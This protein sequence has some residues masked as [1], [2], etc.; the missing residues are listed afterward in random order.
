M[1][2][3]SLTIITIA[4]LA[5]L[6]LLGGEPDIP[7]W[8]Q[9]DTGYMALRMMDEW[10][11][12]MLHPKAPYRGA[13]DVKA[14]EYPIYPL[15]VSLGYKIVGQEYLPWARVV[16]LLF[17]AGSMVFLAL[18]VGRL[19]GEPVGWLTA[20]VYAILPLG[21]PYSRM[22]HPDFCVMFFANG[23]FYFAVLFMERRKVRDAVVAVIFCSGLFLMKAPYG[24]YFGF[25]LGL[26]AL[27]AD[28]KKSLRDL[29]LLASL[30]VIPLGLGLWF[31]DYR[32]QQEAPFEESLTYPMKWTKES[33]NARFFGTI[34][35]R[36]DG[37][38]WN[39]TIK[40]AV[41][42][43]STAPGALLAL[44]GLFL[45][46]R[47]W[48][49]QRRWLVWFL[50]LGMLAYVLL[51][52]PMVASDHDYYSIP[53][54]V[55]VSVLVAI[56]LE[57][58][59]RWKWGAGLVAVSMVLILAGSVYGLQRGPFLYSSPY[60]TRDWQRLE[61]SRVIRET[62][63]PDDLVVSVT[64]GRST[65]WSDPRILW[66]ADRRGWAIE[67]ERLSEDHLNMYRKAGAHVAAIF[68]APG[69]GELEE[70]IPTLAMFDDRSVIPIFNPENENIG[71]VVVVR[72]E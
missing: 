2:L 20:A 28:V 53:L 72:L 43:V 29:V 60:F 34:Q 23:F 45:A 71:N 44:A 65:G 1:K 55:L 42:L 47:G 3:F 35:Q 64:V 58:I 68:I 22:I 61:T 69:R 7:D 9:A 30:F 10:P 26:L 49:D 51:V 67:G 5:R 57:R 38:A 48:R 59:S 25:P 18:A 11:P 17:F 62:T 15:I 56:S 70:E 46:G 41:I 66:R 6:F 13:V 63:D 27:H 33:L 37:E 24:F 16:T 31:N 32:I 52:F 14:A 50:A 4:L 21:I 12:E 54:M 39:W 40:R 8:R 19:W 36:F